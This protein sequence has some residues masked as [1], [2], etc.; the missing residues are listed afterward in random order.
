MECNHESLDGKLRSLGLFKL[1]VK[2]KRIQEDVTAY[3]IRKNTNSK[4]EMKTIRND[5]DI[6]LDSL[7]DFK[8]YIP[9]KDVKYASALN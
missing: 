8:L 6:S 1:Y 5:D 3:L 9:A 4:I 7:V 2:E